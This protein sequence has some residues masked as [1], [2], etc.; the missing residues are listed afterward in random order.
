MSIPILLISKDRPAQADLLLRSI[1]ENS[2][3]TFDLSVIYCASN[4]DFHR[5][6][7]RLQELWPEVSFAIEYDCN[8]QLYKWL[9][10][11]THPLA[12]FF[13]DDCIFYRKSTITENN[14]I[15]LFER[16]PHI[17]SFT[18][19][20]GHNITIQ[21]YTR[22]NEAARPLIWTFLPDNDIVYWSYRDVQR[23]HSLGWPGGIDGFIYDKATLVDILKN[24]NFDHFTNFESLVVRNIDKYGSHRYGMAAPKRSCVVVQQINVTHQRTLHN[25]GRFKE[26][27]EVANKNFLSGQRIDLNSMNFENINCSHSEIPWSWK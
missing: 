23:D 16:Y 2:P 1:E 15:S 20:L 10:S 18:Y 21:D 26:S 9:Y 14:L 19:R 12:G 25:I 27:L 22:G 17:T 3:N 13:A 8:V 4:D 24:E 11:Q 6:Y 7:Y 5:G